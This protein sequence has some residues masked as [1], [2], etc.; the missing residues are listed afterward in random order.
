MLTTLLVGAAPEGLL[1]VRLPEGEMLLLAVA[2]TCNNRR[3]TS[4][5]SNTQRKNLCQLKDSKLYIRQ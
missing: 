2:V 1:T 4:R 3:C 5:H